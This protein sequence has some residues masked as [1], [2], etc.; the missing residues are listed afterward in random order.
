MKQLLYVISILVFI[1]LGIFIGLSFG[2]I[3]QSRSASEE[4]VQVLMEKIEDVMK[5]VAVEG[6]FSEIYDYKDYWHLDWKPF[7]KKALIR[8]QA[9]VSVGYDLEGVDISFRSSDRQILISNL[10][11]PEILSVDHDLDYYDLQQGSFNSFSTEDYNQL[12]K[13][14]KEFIET[15]VQDSDLFNRAESQLD[16]MLHVI[17]EI[18]QSNGWSVVYR[19][20]DPVNFN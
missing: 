16:D 1:G 17:D 7:T 2:N 10:P 9:R 6:Y 18:A 14:A 13:R 15:R 19:E 20:P 8:V 3:F 4:Q 11:T 12:N 5:L